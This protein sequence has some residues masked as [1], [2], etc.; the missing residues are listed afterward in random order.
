MAQLVRRMALL[1][2]ALFLL[3]DS[4]A[5]QA[6]PSPEAREEA[7]RIIAGTAERTAAVKYYTFNLHVDFALRTF[8]FLAFHV[9]GQGKWVRPNLYSVSFRHVPWFAR[10]FEN[11]KMD[12]LE[13]STWD[14]GYDFLSVTRQGDRHNF[15]M[16]DKVAGHIKGVHAELDNDGLRVVQWKYLNGG[17]ITVEIDPVIVDGVPVP[18]TERADIRLPGY[19]V[20]ATAKFADYK[21]FTD[22]EPAPAAGTGADGT[23]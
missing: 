18:G 4:P 1:A 5:P 7:T 9:D 12:P 10:G 16:R 21:I 22:G 2:A 17:T 3:A 23:Q 8:P 20:A 13:P 14:N 15:E 11:V 19:H 6:S